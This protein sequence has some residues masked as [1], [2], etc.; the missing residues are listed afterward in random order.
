MFLRQSQGFP[1]LLL[2]NYRYIFP[3]R[4]FCSSSY[5]YGVKLV[6]RK[7]V[8]FSSASSHILCSFTN[9]VL[10]PSATETP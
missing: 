3:S 1:I 8:V 10:P 6:S 9:M 4:D 7:S 5:T 2:H